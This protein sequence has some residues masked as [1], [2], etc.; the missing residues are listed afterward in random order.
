M[1]QARVTSQIALCV[2]VLECNHHEC[3]MLRNFCV[4]FRGF[5]AFFSTSSVLVSTAYT[6]TGLSAFCF[7]GRRAHSYT[8][9]P[10]MCY[11]CDE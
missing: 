8:M 3:Q 5:K 6:K 11:M 10:A 4:V 7:R 2:F 1:S 9:E